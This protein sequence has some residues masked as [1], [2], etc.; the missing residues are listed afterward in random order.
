[1]SWKKDIL[2]ALN[3][4]NKAYQDI[5]AQVN[6]NGA[7]DDAEIDYASNEVVSKRAYLEAIKTEG[8]L[9]RDGQTLDNGETFLSQFDKYILPQ[10]FSMEYFYEFIKLMDWYY[11]DLELLYNRKYKGIVKSAICYALGFGRA[12]IFYKDGEYGW[13]LIPEDDG[14]SEKIKI[15][16]MKSGWMLQFDA[17]IPKNTK[18][19]EV[20]EIERKKVAILSSHDLNIGMYILFIPWLAKII[21]FRWQKQQNMS[22]CQ[23]VPVISS[24]NE[25]QKNIIAGMLKGVHPNNVYVPKDNQILTGKGQ[26]NNNGSPLNG[27]IDFYLPPSEISAFFSTIEQNYK[28]LIWEF[29]TKFGIPI[30][31]EGKNQDLNA[32]SELDLKYLKAVA[33]DRYNRIRDFVADVNELK[34]GNKNKDINKHVNKELETESNNKKMTGEQDLEGIEN[35]LI[36]KTPDYRLKFVKS[37]ELS[38]GM[39]GNDNA[40]EKHNIEKEKEEKENE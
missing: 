34:K 38:N 15:Q 17:Y 39:N 23:I 32:Y 9:L 28:S 24:N 29:Y 4:L 27:M 13:C 40:S 7:S 5:S 26:T 25:K 6:A 19:Y 35:T 16:P 31:S 36:I 10:E 21:Y 12:G 14:M 18:S 3:N 37:N 20:I 2:A 22:L 30:G 33:N 1:M 11:E 8:M